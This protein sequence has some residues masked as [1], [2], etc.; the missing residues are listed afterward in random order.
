[1]SRALLLLLAAG[2]AGCA[3]APPRAPG[4]VSVEAEG[5]A[6]ETPGDPSGSRL[7]ALADAQKR[8]VEKAAGV[9]VAASTRVDK[10]VAVRQRVWA[11]ARGR[12]ERWDLLADRRE[13]GFRKLTI[14]AVV[15]LD[16]EGEPA[17]PPPGEARLRV[18]AQGPAAAGLRRA[19][20]ARGYE[21]VESGEQ[22]VVAAAASTTLSRDP[23]LRPFVSGRT[24]L[25]VTVKDPAGGVLWEAA[26]DASALDADPLLAAAR[27]AD[28]AGEAA[29]RA[30]AEGL[31][32]ALWAR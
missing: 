12:I 27:A 29:G 32:E 6:A 31:A 5:W 22:Y 13:D 3:G 8:A 18:A 11:D 17:A 9:R 1:M 19:L 2:L 14:R 21:V 30:A 16:L 15:R 24:R 28:A 23:R 7:R 25:S 4:R 20:A 26:R 10:G